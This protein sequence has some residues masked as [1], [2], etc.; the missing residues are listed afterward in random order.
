MTNPLDNTNSYGI[1]VVANRGPFQ[2]KAAKA[3]EKGSRRA[4]EGIKS[5]TQPQ[6]R[7]GAAARSGGKSSAASSQRAK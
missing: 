3:F 6:R 7:K 5:L 4:T 1:R 2:E